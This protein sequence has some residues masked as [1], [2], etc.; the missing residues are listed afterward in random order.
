MTETAEKDDTV[1][2]LNNLSG[3]EVEKRANKASDRLK[4]K[5]KKYSSK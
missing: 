5:L 3:E 1:E 2:K 4:H